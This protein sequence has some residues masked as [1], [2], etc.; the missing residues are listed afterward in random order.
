MKIN[1]YMVV[2][3]FVV[4]SCKDDKAKLFDAQD[5]VDKAIAVS[6]G[7]FYKKSN[8]SYQ[9]RDRTYQSERIEGKKILKRITY[10]D[11]LLIIDIKEPSEFCRYT[12]DEIVQVPDTLAFAY[13]NSV[14]SVH[15][16]SELPYGL[17][18]RAVKKELLEGTTINNIEY[19][20]IKITFNEIGGGNDFEDIFVYW[21]NK[22]T[23]KPDYLAYVYYTDGGGTRFRKAYNERYVNGIRFVDYKNFKP[24]NK[25]SSIYEI[26]DLYQKG[27]LQ[28]LSTIELKN[29][30][31]NRLL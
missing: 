27:E 16:F 31:V 24:K 11:S 30:N 2:A 9:F 10:I 6:G 15:Y 3:L 7:D 22:E 8:V 20:K 17:N 19:Y 25:E 1:V 13:A 5:I 21:I 28:L 14:N 4:Y 29:V 26:D 23:F 12:N 18:A